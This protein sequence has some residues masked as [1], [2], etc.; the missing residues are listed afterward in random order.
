MIVLGMKKITVVMKTMRA[1]NGVPD[2]TGRPGTNWM[3]MRMLSV[4]RPLAA[5][6]P[7]SV[8]LRG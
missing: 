6:M 3:R 7:P 8:A 2:Q 4:I 1:T 5:R